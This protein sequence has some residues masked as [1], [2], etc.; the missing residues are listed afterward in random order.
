MNEL[1]QALRASWEGYEILRQKFLGAP[2]FGNDDPYVDLIAREMHRRIEHE[3]ERFTCY[4]ER[5]LVQDGSGASSWFAMSPL[6]GATPDGRRDKEFLADAVLSPMRGMDKKGPT[7]VIKSASKVDHI[8]GMS[9]LLNQ[10]FLPQFLQGDFRKKFADY[11]RAWGDSGIY[12]IQFNVFDV[13]TL[14]D[15]QKDPEAHG[16]LVI[17]VAGYSAF[18]VDLTKNIQDGIISRTAQSLG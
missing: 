16:D 4:F 15:A 3:V 11:L 10:R 2:K 1:L 9:Y 13:D 17:R 7:A 5:P 6:T 18:F 8:D 12:H 14:R